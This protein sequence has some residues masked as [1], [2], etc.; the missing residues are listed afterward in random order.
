MNAM[1]TA[2]AIPPFELYAIRYATNRTRT[3]GQNF[4]FE[5]QPAALQPMDFYS[6]V[7][8]GEAGTF[9]IDTGMAKAKA[10]KHGHEFLHSPIDGLRSLGVDP[11]RVERVI[12]THLHYDHTGHVDAFPRARFELQKAEM[13]YVVSPYMQHRW[14][15]RAYEVD[16]IARFV[17]L[18]HGDRL[19]LHGPD[20]Q[21]APGLSVHLVGGHCAGQEIVRVW[22]Q[23]GWVVL[24]SD[25]LHYYEEFERGV[26]FTVAYSIGDMLTAHD[27]IREL[28]DSDAHVVPAHD[29]LVMRRY[30][31]AKPEIADYVVRLDVPPIG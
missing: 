7:A 16:E 5:A 10:Q 17:E 21:I 15:R 28:A 11:G 29:P 4:I 6:W 30:P 24:A 2:G 18:L 25:A 20:K 27:R 3:R 8:I 14:C 12:M 19:V 13:D 9:V 1:A 26:P 23:R 22:T 31:A